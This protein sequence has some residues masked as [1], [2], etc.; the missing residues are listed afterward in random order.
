MITFCGEESFSLSSPR[1]IR[2]G[3]GEGLLERT[4]FAIE[5]EC[6]RAGHHDVVV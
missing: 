6:C 5:D 1:S 4:D 2:E 3:L